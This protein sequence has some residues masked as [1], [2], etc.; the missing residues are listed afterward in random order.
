M[1]AFAAGTAVLAAL[2][3]S[4]L[5]VLRTGGAPLASLLVS[6]GRTA[7]GSPVRHRAR[8]LL[9]V[10]QV[11]LALVLLS[12]AALFARSFRRLS[13]V[14]PGFDAHSAVAFRLALPDAAYPTTADAAGAILRTLHAL[15]V[16]PGAKGAGV[17]TQLPLDDEAAQDSAVFIEDHPTP[18]GKL[19]DVHPMVFATPGYFGAMGIPLVAGR[20]YGPP[21]PSRD[22]SLSPREVVVSEAFAVRYWTP[23]TAVGKRIRMNPRDPWSTVVGVVGSVHG[24]GLEKPPAEV[25]YN[26]LVTAAASGAAWTPRDVAFVVRSGGDVSATVS[27][28]R[29]AVRAAAPSLPV[30]RVMALDDLLSHAVARTTFTLL[31]LGVAAAMAMAIGAT[32][33]YGVIAYLVALRTR[34]IGVRLALGARPRDVRRMVVRRAVVDA[35]TGVGVGLVGAVLLTRGLGTL[36]FDVSPTDPVSLAAAALLLLA[37]AAAAGWIPARRAAALDPAITLRG[38]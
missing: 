35:A 2:V 30:Y 8:R 17:A 26:Q 19:P 21:D 7:T 4:A 32:G 29:A 23:A 13:A 3:V 6:D 34:E 27:A 33:I 25:V 24:D 22:P 9:V 36:L 38:E 5:P 16:I 12:G 1:L 10:S 15:T 31:L 28:I 18:A 37:T 14:N 20:L 11:A